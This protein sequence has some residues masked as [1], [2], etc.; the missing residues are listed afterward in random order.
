M[1]ARARIRTTEVVR[2]RSIPHHIG[3]CGRMSHPSNGGT[4]VRPLSPSGSPCRLLPLP[5][6]VGCGPGS[7][8]GRS[9]RL[10]P[11]APCRLG[12]SCARRRA[13][14]GRSPWRCPLALPFVFP[15]RCRRVRARVVRGRPRLPASLSRGFGLDPFCRSLLD[16]L[17]RRPV[18]DCAAPLFV[19]CGC[20]CRRR[21]S[22]SPFGLP[23]PG[24]APSPR[25]R[26]GSPAL[27]ERRCRRGRP[28]SPCARPG[29]RPVR[30]APA[31]PRRR[32]R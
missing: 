11:A 17:R 29:H 25:D 7:R 12:P 15:S 13:A 14:A 1:S 5:S 27:R 6:C 2:A 31:L 10:R 24:A 23:F 30:P 26:A 20:R 16:G 28:T 8:G 22:R 3:L 9:C 32:R 4:A 18:V 19:L 21:R